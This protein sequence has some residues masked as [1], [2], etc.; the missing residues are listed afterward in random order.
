MYVSTDSTS[1]CERPRSGIVS[2]YCLTS[3][4]AVG[5]PDCTIL[6]GEEIH[7]TSQSCDWTLVMPLR[8]GPTVLPLPIVWHAAHFEVKIAAPSSARAAGAAYTHKNA[9]TAAAIR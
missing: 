4:V 1:A 2:G 6:L 9:I 7:F 5:S 3:F 8:S